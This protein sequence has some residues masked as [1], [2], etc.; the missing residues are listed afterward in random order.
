MYT[1][2]RCKLHVPGSHRGHADKVAVSQPR[3]VTYC[4]KVSSVANR[5]CTFRWPA[6]WWPPDA[7][8]FLSAAT[9]CENCPRGDAHRA[10]HGAI[11]ESFRLALLDLLPRL[12]RF[13]SRLLRDRI[14]ADQGRKEEPTPPEPSASD[15]PIATIDARMLAAILRGEEKCSPMDLDDRIPLTEDR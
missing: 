12:A 11:R 1:P 15:R 6:C 5:S 2:W 13:V 7:G 4:S 9:H 14:V 10:S 8:R 3:C